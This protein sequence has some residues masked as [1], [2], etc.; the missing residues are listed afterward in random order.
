MQSVQKILFLPQNILWLISTVCDTSFVVLDLLAELVLYYSKNIEGSL[1]TSVHC[2]H[3]LLFSLGK[4]DIFHCTNDTTCA[5][6]QSSAL[7][8]QSLTKIKLPGC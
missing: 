3:L 6:L 4:H 2:G 1:I 5:N 7:G 8:F